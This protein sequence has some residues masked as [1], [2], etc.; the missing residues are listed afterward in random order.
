MSKNVDLHDWT[1]V[2]IDT[3]WLEGRVAISIVNPDH[4]TVSLLA[5][6]FSDLKITKREEWGESVSINKVQ[7]PNILENGNNIIFIEMQS[8]D[9]LTIE[10][11]SFN[12]PENSVKP[13]G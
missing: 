8:G 3:N 9:V 12:F 11:A 4:E 10:A 6:Q 13:H 7:G 2:S 1:L 5:Q